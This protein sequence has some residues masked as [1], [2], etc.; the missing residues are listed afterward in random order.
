MGLVIG[1]KKGEAV[2]IDGDIRVEVVKNED[3]L[4]RLNIDAPKHMSIE[5]EELVKRVEND[6][7]SF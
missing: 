2:I 7:N 6:K 3:G 1:R 4:M 5:R